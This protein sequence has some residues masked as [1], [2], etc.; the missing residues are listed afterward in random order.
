MLSGLMDMEEGER[1]GAGVVGPR[2]NFIAQ[3]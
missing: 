1:Y 3:W 2:Q